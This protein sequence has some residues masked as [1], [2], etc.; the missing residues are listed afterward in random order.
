MGVVKRLC[1]RYVNR[2][3]ESTETSAYFLP[4]RLRKLVIV[5]CWFLTSWC[6]A[7]F[8]IYYSPK[9][10]IRR[11]EFVI[12]SHAY[13]FLAVERHGASDLSFSVFVRDALRLVF[14]NRT[15]INHPV[16]SQSALKVSYFVHDGDG[17]VAIA[18]AYANDDRRAFGLLGDL[19]WGTRA[20]VRLPPHN[21]LRGHRVSG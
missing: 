20:I 8:P 11:V 18:E 10:T 3:V 9:K 13:N 17:G 19:G 7:W 4:S 14:L 2:I 12:S 5:F 15:E 21:L 6:F 1:D 16:L